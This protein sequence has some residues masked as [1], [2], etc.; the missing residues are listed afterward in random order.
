MRL[1]IRSCLYLAAFIVPI[2]LVS[3]GCQVVHDPG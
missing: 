1:I 3:A 2:M